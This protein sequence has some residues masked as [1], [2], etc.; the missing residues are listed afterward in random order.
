[1]IFK[2][3]KFFLFIFLFLNTTIPLKANIFNYFN[4]Q[5]NSGAIITLRYTAQAERIINNGE[6]YA[7]QQVHLQAKSVEGN[8]LIDAPTIL[9][10][11]ETF[12]FSGKIRC[13]NTCIICVQDPSLLDLKSFTYEGPGKLII[14]DKK[15]FNK[16]IEQLQT[17]FSL[18]PLKH[19]TQEFVYR[20]PIQSIGVGGIIAVLIINGILHRKK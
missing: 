11:S 1:M 10:E 20:H 5:T 16:Y 3:L 9:I 19:V 6:Y 4:S 14:T 15:S 17:S 12:K 2:N 8:G 13:Y 18:N 7:L